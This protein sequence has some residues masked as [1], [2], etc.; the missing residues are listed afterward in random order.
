MT[1]ILIGITLYR[2][3][4][5]FLKSLSEFYS[6]IYNSYEIEILV[7][8]NKQLVDAQNEIA[9]YFLNSSSEYLLFL[10][11]DH[12]G[13]TPQMLEALL[14]ADA[15][16]TAVKFY[17]RHF[18]YLCCLMKYGNSNNP[19]RKYINHPMNQKGYA[20]IDL[21]PFG[22]TLIR[23]NTFNYLEKPY[24][25]LNDEPDYVTHA[26]DKNFS[27]RL[28]AK[29]VKLLGY[30]DEC[31]VHYGLDESNLDEYRHKGI[32]E[33]RRKNLINKFRRLQCKKELKMPD[34]I[35]GVKDYD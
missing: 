16:V 7:V 1:R 32:L 28:R 17:S 6:K 15:P 22:M 5:D 21:T 14:K 2:P 27:D 31:L 24:F 18:P 12:W 10:E 33:F 8:S 35:L 9:E 4:K 26:T 20:E 34:E 29:G 11:D 3:H 13:H 30:Y 25:R 19:K 23:K